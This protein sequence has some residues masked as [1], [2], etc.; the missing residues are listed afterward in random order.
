MMIT[1]PAFVFCFFDSVC[2]LQC[3]CAVLF[4]QQINVTEQMKK[5]EKN[6]NK[7]NGDNVC[8]FVFERLYNHPKNIIKK[9]ECLVTKLN[10]YMVQ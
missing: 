6:I 9:Y 7:Q 1:K 8:L 10:I 5:K 2:M 3:F 4:I